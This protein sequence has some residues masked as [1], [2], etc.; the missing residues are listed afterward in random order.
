L[1]DILLFSLFAQSALD[2][3][4]KT[5]RN[6]APN[7]G[8]M[9][10][11]ILGIHD[12]TNIDNVI[13]NTRNICKVTHADPRCIASCVAVTTAI[14]LMLQGKHFDQS[15][16]TY[17]EKEICN[18]AYEYACKELDKSKQVNKRKHETLQ[19]KLSKTK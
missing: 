4:E 2:V 13:D 8:V 1:T 11:S 12:F 9:R 18:K 6:A 16:H 15:T 7:G 10:T 14:A 17:N 5:G 19:T 3:W